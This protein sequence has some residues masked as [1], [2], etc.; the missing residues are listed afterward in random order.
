MVV[1]WAVW[2][3]NARGLVAALHASRGDPPVTFRIRPVRGPKGA[4]ASEDNTS[5]GHTALRPP[6][7]AHVGEREGSLAPGA[8]RESTRPDP[9]GA[10]AV[11]GVGPDA[12]RALPEGGRGHTHP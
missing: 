11:K 3:A 9:N 8:N 1:K 10:L 4:T 5:H 12:A 7:R 6:Q 2:L